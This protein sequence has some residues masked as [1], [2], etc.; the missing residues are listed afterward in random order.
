MIDDTL[1]TT[2]TGLGSAAVVGLG[3]LPEI[4]SVLVAATTI[5]YLIVKIRNDFNK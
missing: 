1:K 3:I 5:I 4:M 2:V